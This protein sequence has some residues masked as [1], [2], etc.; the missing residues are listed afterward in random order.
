MELANYHIL[1]RILYF[2]PYFA[3]MHPGRTL[4][5]FG[6]ISALV[7]VLNAVGVAW[8][9]N[10]NIED[11][12]KKVGEALLKASLIIQIAVIVFFV[13][14]VAVFQRRCAKQGGRDHARRIRPPIVTLYLSSALVMVRCIY[15]TVEY[16]GENTQRRPGMDPMS[17]SPVVRYEWFFYVFEGAVML[18][19]ACMWNL[20]HPR[21]Y[22]PEDHRVYLAQDGRTELVGDGYKD[23]RHFLITL[24]DPFGWLLKDGSAKQTPFW[25]TNGFGKDGRNGSGSTDAGARGPAAV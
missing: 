13:S 6:T 8:M 23:N 10:P 3:P 17:L 18:A 25:E 19:N 16:F 11:D 24:L 7:E 2:V 15:R 12:I 20:R 4:T 21:L 1:G 5:T 9:V 14:L 22:L